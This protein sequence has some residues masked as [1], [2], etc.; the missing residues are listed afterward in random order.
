[1]DADGTLA[2]A[3]EVHEDI[4]RMMLLHPFVRRNP[5]KSADR[6]DFKFDPVAKLTVEDGAATLTAFTA[7][8]VEHSQKFLPEPPVGWVVCGGG[9]HNPALMGALRDRLEAPVKSAEDVGWRGDDLEAECFGY[10]AVRSLKKL[11]LSYPKTTRVP[12]PI[13][14]GV[15]HR[16]GI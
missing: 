14:G 10:L 6:Y 8:C 11:P 13:C 5:P 4:V 3:G 1:M 9:R 7:A 16:A 12:Q 2:S 15:F